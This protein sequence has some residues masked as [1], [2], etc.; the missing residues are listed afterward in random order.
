[1]PSL[2][3]SDR[4]LEKNI[5]TT[6]GDISELFADVE[7]VKARAKTKYY[8]CI[9]LLAASI[10]EALVYHLIDCSCNADPRLLTDNPDVKLRARH[11][12]PSPVLGTVKK[13]FIAEEVVKPSTIKSI[14]PSFKIMNKFCYKNGLIDD[15]ILKEIEYIRKKRNQIHLQTLDSTS[16][17]YTLAMLERVGEAMIMLYDKLE[18]LNP[19]S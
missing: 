8:K 14:A 1:M 3:I 15:D 13:L 6:F 5:R 19:S 11:T 9:F 12:L 4:T 10:V 18:V 2:P 17:S 7:R 16:R